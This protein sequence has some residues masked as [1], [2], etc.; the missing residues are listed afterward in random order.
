MAS[1]TCISTRPEQ[2]A[3]K[4]PLS[5][6]MTQD[7]ALIS[8]VQLRSGA[9]RWLAFAR[10][11]LLT[12]ALGGLVDTRSRLTRPTPMQI[13][14]LPAVLA[15]SAALAFG[16]CA[17]HRSYPESW[18]PLPPPPAA[19]CRH[20][21][22]DYSDRGEI[23]GAPAHASLTQQLFGPNTAWRRATRVGFSLPRTEVL[24]ITVWQ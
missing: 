5:A 15:T 13:I 20:F 17:V 8:A 2:Y 14:T 18:E 4:H 6:E 9:A 19:D 16:G 12:A 23:P 10:L 11:R 3:N 21:E 7:A 22:G 1:V 24:E